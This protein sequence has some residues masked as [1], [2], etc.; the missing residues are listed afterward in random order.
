MKT[1][2]DTLGLARSNIVE[3]VRGVRPKRAPLVEHPLDKLFHVAPVRI[4][5]RRAPA[6]VSS[7]GDLACL[8]SVKVNKVLTAITSALAGGR[9]CR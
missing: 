8:S 1:V 3:R 2:T 7:L 6:H 4:G 9:Q 5:Q